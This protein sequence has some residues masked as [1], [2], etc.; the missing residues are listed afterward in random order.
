MLEAFGGDLSKRLHAGAKS[1]KHECSRCHMHKSIV[2]EF[3]RKT[4]SK[5]SLCKSCVRSVGKSLP[6]QEQ[7]S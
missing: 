1:K 7:E 6:L 5:F 4:G 2:I 3:R